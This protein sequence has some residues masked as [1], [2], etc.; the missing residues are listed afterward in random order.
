MPS[1]LHIIEPEILTKIITDTE[2]N[3]AELH[4]AES[5]Y[6][7]ELRWDPIQYIRSISFDFQSTD[8]NV[9]SAWLQKLITE[10]P[11]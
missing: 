6:N 2:I 4:T 5:F 7:D 8:R 10:I 1:N 11:E 9:I 3:S